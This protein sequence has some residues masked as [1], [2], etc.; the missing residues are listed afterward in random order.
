[1]RPGRVHV[2][3]PCTVE[4]H[5]ENRTT[6]ATPVLQL[7]DAV[8]TTAGAELL[9]AP[10]AGHGRSTVAY[11]LPTGQ[12]GLLAVGPLRAEVADPFGLC[13]NPFE[14]APVLEVTVLPRVEEIA[15][16]PR[17]SGPDPEGSAEHARSVGRSGEDFVG[18]R[19]YVVGDDPR[20]VH[21]PSLA[22]ADDE[23]LVRQDDVPWQGRVSVVLDTRANLHDPTTFERSVVAA[24]SIVRTHIRRGD[25]VRLATTSGADYGEH[26]GAGHLQRMLEHLA[27]VGAT[28]QGS[29]H[30]TLSVVG[31]GGA[32]ALVVITGR[33]PES[34]L[35]VLESL[36]ASFPV[37]RMVRFDQSI[38]R[39]RGR[40]TSVLGVG[41]DETFAT[42]WNSTAATRRSRGARIAG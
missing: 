15:P 5:I 29:L 4:L 40:N 8:T 18:L 11:R 32:G 26:T 21:W 3:N 25:H 38:R 28:R 20:K 27:V 22:R 31:R 24:A 19:P 9:L 23:L 30:D 41:P 16:L 6:R 33:P 37:R 1:M 13:H 2:G 7:H 12:R 14:A 35:D 36:G 42:V 17:T 39:T 10:L 34:D